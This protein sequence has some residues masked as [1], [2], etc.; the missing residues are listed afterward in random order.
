MKL[1]ALYEEA[2]DRLT[3]AGVPEPEIDAGL[4]LEHCCGVSRHDLILRG[5]EEPS[6]AAQEKLRRLTDKRC[7]RI[8]LQHLLGST[9]FMGLDFLVNEHV[10][11]PRPDTE[12][13]TEEALRYLSDGFR[14]L[15]LCTG[16]GCILLSLLHYSNDC[17]GTGVDLSPEALD[18]ARRNAEVL[19][20]DAAER[21]RFLQGDLWEGIGGERF[22][23]IV[24]NPPYIPTADLVTLMPEVRDHEPHLALDG[25]PDGLAF[26]RRIVRFAPDHLVGGGMLLL[27]IG[28]DQGAAV[29][30]MM[31][32][33]GF[34]D[35]EIVRDYGGNDRVVKGRKS[36]L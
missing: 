18:V 10:L 26:Y 25:G 32:A 4:L 31:L 36:A 7:E 24:S 34:L 3:T 11:C 33:A 22:E 28:Y 2:K 30:D 8:P 9:C 14:I 29:T 1:R 21:V 27:E 16:S 20:P 35:V 13:L 6:D 23:I 15:D 19:L 17:T 5:E 12:I